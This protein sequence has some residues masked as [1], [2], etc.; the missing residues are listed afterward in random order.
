M[1]VFVARS[2]LTYLS[3]PAHA[4]H[5][6]FLSHDNDSGYRKSFDRRMYK[7]RSAQN[8]VQRFAIQ[9]DRVALELLLEEG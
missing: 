1:V 2:K 3:G 7:M 4:E 9:Q 8:L 5:A 6:L